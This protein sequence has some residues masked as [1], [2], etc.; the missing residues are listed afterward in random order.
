MKPF[1]IPL[2]TEH[3]EAFKNGSKT[4]EFRIYGARWNERTCTVGRVV[5]LSKGYGKKHRIS[6]VVEGFDWYPINDPAHD[7]NRVFG[8]KAKGKTAAI[9]HIRVLP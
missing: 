4:I 6:G 8:E 5:T 9:I 3:F 7:F 1:F 2:H